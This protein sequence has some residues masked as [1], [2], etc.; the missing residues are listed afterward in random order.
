MNKSTTLVKLGTAFMIGTVLMV[1]GTTS[2]AIAQETSVNIGKLK[3]VLNATRT[4]IE[5]Y[6]LAGALTQ[7]DLAEQLLSGEG[8]MTTAANMTGNMSS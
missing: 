6:D 1:V 3:E 5:A 4:A 7:V 8:N 2:Q